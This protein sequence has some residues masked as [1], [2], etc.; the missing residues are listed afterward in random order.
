MDINGTCSTEE[1]VA[2]YL[3]QKGLSAV[4]TT[5]IG[6]QKAEELIFFKREKYPATT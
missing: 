1:I 2:P 4:N 6:S 3:T 5:R